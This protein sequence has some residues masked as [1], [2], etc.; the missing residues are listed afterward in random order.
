VA[1]ILPGT[2]AQ[3]VVVA[4]D[5][6]ARALVADDLGGVLPA[7]AVVQVVDAGGRGEGA[8]PAA[9][10]A[11]VHDQVLREVWRRRRETLEHLQ[12][13]LGRAEYA[14]AGVPAVVAALRKAQ[15]D[16]VV[17]SHDPASTLR[18]WIGPDATDFGT[19]PAEAAATGVS[20]PTEDRFDAALVRAAVG[21]G[22][23]LLVTP[24]A[25]DYV[26]DGVGA[27]LRYE[28]RAAPS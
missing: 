19:D 27:L 6:R 1:K 28:D 9:L 23:Q 4:G 17:L 16:T 18:A 8:S 12:Q 20:N 7:R 11:A 25:H 22:A 10:T 24:G 2:E 21:T 26:T 5:V 3:L 13:N 15:V 14:V